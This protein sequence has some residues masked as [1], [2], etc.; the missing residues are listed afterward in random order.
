M[1]WK[2]SVP[3]LVVSS[4]ET[5]KQDGRIVDVDYRHVAGV[6]AIV[7]RV[8]ADG[9]CRR[10]CIDVAVI[11][12]IILAGNRQRLAFQLVDVNTL[13]EE[14]IPQFVSLDAKL[15][16][17]LAGLAGQYDLNVAVLPARWSAG[18]WWA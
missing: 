10:S 17:T 14:T 8:A 2:V 13:A 7:V 15:T 16:V 1:I 5:G 3:R 12:R 9:R 18:R 6:Q 4:P 11:D